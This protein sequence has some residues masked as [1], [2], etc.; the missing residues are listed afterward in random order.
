MLSRYHTAAPHH[1]LLLLGQRP[2]G[3]LSRDKYDKKKKN[4]KGQ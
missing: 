4:K 3:L 2:A 1:L